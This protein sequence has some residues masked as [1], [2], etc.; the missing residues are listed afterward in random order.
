[1]KNCTEMKLSPLEEAAVQAILNIS[2]LST[3]QSSSSKCCAL[4]KKWGSPGAFHRSQISRTGVDGAFVETIEATLPVG[5]WARCKDFKED[6]RK[7]KIESEEA[8][9]GLW[10]E[11]VGELVKRRSRGHRLFRLGWPLWL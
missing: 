6:C 1:M 9:E 10:R 2:D 11:S 8:P 4:L 3:T 7:G 5:Q